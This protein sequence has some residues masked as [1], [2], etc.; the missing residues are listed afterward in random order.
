MKNKLLKHVRNIIVI[1]LISF[2]LE[3][4]LMGYY[5]CINKLY[6]HKHLINNTPE[7]LDLT[8]F[9]LSGEDEWGYVYLEYNGEIKNVYNIEVI[10]KETSEDKYIQAVYNDSTSVMLKADEEQKIFKIYL[11]EATDINNFKLHYFKDVLNISDIDKIVVNGNLTY[12]PEVC[13]S[14]MNVLTFFVIIMVAYV[15]FEIYKV[16]K[17]KQINI[18]KGKMFLIIGFVVGTILCFTNLALRTYDEHAHFWKAYE[19]SMGNI[20]S[21]YRKSMPKSVYETVI[22]ENGLYHIESNTYS[23]Q[24]IF[25]QLNK[26]LNKEETIYI[27]PGTVSG[28]SPFSYIPQVIGIFIGR[29]LELNPNIIAIFGRMTN[30]I[31]YLITIFIA[32]KLM[33]KEKWKNIVIICALLPMSMMMAASLSPDSIIISTTILAIS[34]VLHLKYKK[35]KIKLKNI[36]IFGILCMIPTICKIVYFCIA[37]L[38]FTIPKDKFKNTKQYLLSFLLVVCI[39]S[40]PYLLW[41]KIPKNDNAIVIRSN[42]KEQTYFTLSDPMRDLYTAGN[43]LYKNTEEYIFTSIGG[44]YTPNII[45]CVY[46]LMILMATFGKDG[47][48]KE[49]D[50]KLLKKD[51]III[52]IICLLIIAMIFGA[53][54][55]GFTRSMYTIVEGVQGRYFLP[56]L[57]LILIL[58]ESDKIKYNIK[59]ARLKYLIVTLILYIPSILNII[60]HFNR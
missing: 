54:Y 28:L 50:I 19:I 35:D 6:E 58:F 37:F 9:S 45:S 52:S 60:E 25:Q 34:Y 29:M 42:Q 55:V 14:M 40:I 30:L 2:V 32:I 15:G 10:M 21:D 33:P 23:Y 48:Q 47:G 57:P 1:L 11:N 53:L 49:D 39:I 20:T 22:D 16:L 4:L 8:Q 13:F 5:A 46:I 24:D 44:W 3:V 27:H 18:D 36:I 31:Y 17:S 41:N 43:T 56:I 7:E 51:I 12:V 38:F 26:G 59:N